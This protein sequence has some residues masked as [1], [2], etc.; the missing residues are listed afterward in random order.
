MVG[1][2]LPGPRIGAPPTVLQVELHWD[3]NTELTAV[4]NSWDRAVEISPPVCTLV[5][6]P[7][8][9]QLIAVP[10]RSPLDY[11][12]GKWGDTG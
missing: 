3:R 8:V 2:E 6:S 5:Y 12:V 7:G 1:Q 10:L 9:A 11:P 4:I